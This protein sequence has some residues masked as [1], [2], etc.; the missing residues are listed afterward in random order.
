MIAGERSPGLG[1]L[2]RV[3][4]LFV[5]SSIAACAE[6]PQKGRPV[7]LPVAD[8]NDIRFSPDTLRTGPVTGRSQP[9]CARRSGI[10]VVWH[11]GRSKALR[12]LRFS[13]LPA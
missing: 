10:H 6:V 4:L 2:M 12:R 5:C 7:I 8:G 13:G 3:G 9:H 11:V 1:L